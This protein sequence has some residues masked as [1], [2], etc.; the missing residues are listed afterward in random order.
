M[1]NRTWNLLVSIFL[2]VPLLFVSMLTVYA[3]EAPGDE[4]L[5]PGLL[6]EG[7]VPDPEDVDLRMEYGDL[8]TEEQIAALEEAYAQLKASVSAA[9]DVYQD[10]IKGLKERYRVTVQDA[11]KS[12]EDED[13]LGEVL[14]QLKK[15][16]LLAYEEIQKK[17][18][19]DVL[20][21][22]QAFQKAADAALIPAEITD[23]LIGWHANKELNAANELINFIE[24]YKNLS[25]NGKSGESQ[26]QGN[27]TMQQNVTQNSEKNKEENNNQGQQNNQEQE[28]Q[29]EQNDENNQNP[30]NQQGNQSGQQN[31]Q[32]QSSKSKNAH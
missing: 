9:E 26:G 17:L 10:A 29:K 22:R 24:S 32:S 6:D 4:G 25:G 15:D 16:I 3:E 8:L 2:V 27:G 19:S 12:I 7:K 30:G 21:A 31:A 11:V 14:D 1:K 18:D 13:M 5:Q 28:K 20:S 23:T